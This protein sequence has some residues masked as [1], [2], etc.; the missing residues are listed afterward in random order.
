MRLRDLGDAHVIGEAGNA[1]AV[2][3]AVSFAGD[4]DGPRWSGRLRPY[5][6]LA[7]TP[8]RYTLRICGEDIGALAVQTV[9]HT[10]D[11]ELADFL[12]IGAPGEPLRELAAAGGARNAAPPRFP[13]VASAVEPTALAKLL[14]PFAAAFG[15]L[16]ARR[17]A[18]RRRGSLAHGRR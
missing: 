18:R 11:H 10:G 12:G 1:I 13:R 8:G 4:G 2:H 14:A 15:R 6:P 9:R 3:V 17:I 5:R 16:L 7:L